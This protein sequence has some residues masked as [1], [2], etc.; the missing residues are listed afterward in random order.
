[1]TVV[2]TI[3]K[4]YVTKMTHNVMHEERGAALRL[5]YQLKLAIQKL[6]GPAPDQLEQQ[7]LTGLKEG[8]VE[9]IVAAKKEK[10]LANTHTIQP[11]TVGGKDIRT[12]K[13]KRQDLHLAQYALA[14]KQLFEDAQAYD[15]TEKELIATL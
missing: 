9:R 7:T 3:P 13:T 5:L 12:M 14:Q 6:E 1:M 2:F 8:T 15:A 4:E 10:T 11:A